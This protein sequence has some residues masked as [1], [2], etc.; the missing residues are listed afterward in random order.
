MMSTFLKS[1]TFRQP[2][3]VHRKA[4]Y[5]AHSHSPILYGTSLFLSNACPILYITSDPEAI[6]AQEIIGILLEQPAFDK[7]ALT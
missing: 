4:L 3:F 2:S 7:T 1:L 6:T 5:N